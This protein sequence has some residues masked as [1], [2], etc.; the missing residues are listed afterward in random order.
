MFGTEWSTGRDSTEWKMI[1]HLI[2]SLGE[3]VILNPLTLTFYMSA[4]YP[5]EIHGLCLVV[6]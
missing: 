1:R 4:V 6:I 2:I 5:V 3:T